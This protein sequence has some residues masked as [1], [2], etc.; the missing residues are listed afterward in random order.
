[1]RWKRCRGRNRKFNF[2][3]HFV[4]SSF[5]GSF[6]KEVWFLRLTFIPWLACPSFQLEQATALCTITPLK[7]PSLPLQFFWVWAKRCKTTKNEKKLKS[8]FWKCRSIMERTFEKFETCLK[9]TLEKAKDSPKFLKWMRSLWAGMIFE[10]F[11]FKAWFFC[12]PIGG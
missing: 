6:F 3:L 2:L 10:L 9:N 4:S 8:V 11:Q 1:M 12:C 5:L 7:H